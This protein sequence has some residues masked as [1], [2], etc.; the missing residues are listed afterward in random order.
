MNVKTDSLKPAPF[1]PEGRT[2]NVKDL[3]RSIEKYGFWPFCPILITSDNMIADG[4]RR[5]TAAK[6]LGLEDVPVEVVE[7]EVGELWAQFNG[8]RRDVS[9]RES[10]YAYTHGMGTLPE[11]G[12]RAIERLK[13]IIGEKGLKHLSDMNISPNILSVARSIAAYCGDK[14]DAFTAKVIYWL[15]ENSTQRAAIMAMQNDIPSKVLKQAVEENRII[16][17]RGYS[18]E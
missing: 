16:V 12:R 10:L 1:N 18:I 3:E 6:N 7:M 9:S 5:W 17:S 4:H 11:R 2:Q 15:I 13:K 8:T 14:S